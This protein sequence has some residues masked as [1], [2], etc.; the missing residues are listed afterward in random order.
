ML[1]PAP[2]K[3]IGVVETSKAR[4]VMMTTGEA[5]RRMSDDWRYHQKQSV[6]L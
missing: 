4:I 6:L 3:T 2:I 1:V 5:H